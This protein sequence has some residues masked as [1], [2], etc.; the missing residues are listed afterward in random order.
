M[1]KEMFQYGVA[2]LSLKAGEDEIWR[3]KS[4]NSPESLRVVYMVREKESDEEMINYVIGVT[5]EARKELCENRFNVLVSESLSVHVNVVFTD[6]MKDM[7]LK[8]SISNLGGAPCILCM[9]IGVILTILRR[10]SPS[11]GTQTT[12]WSWFNSW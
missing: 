11:T 12:Q 10:A 6:S 8:R 7:K 5:D 1:Q 9:K 2:P 4:P 3:N